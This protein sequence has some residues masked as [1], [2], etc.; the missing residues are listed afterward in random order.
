MDAEDSFFK[1]LQPLEDFPRLFS[2]T[3]RFGKWNNKTL[4]IILVYRS[5]YISFIL[6]IVMVL[7]GN[8]E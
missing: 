6:D 7:S 4:G 2:K 3:E 5:F 8:S 1:R